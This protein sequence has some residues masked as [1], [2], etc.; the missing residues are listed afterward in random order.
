[1]EASQKAAVEIERMWWGE[2]GGDPDLAFDEL[3]N[4]VKDTAQSLYAQIQQAM[5]E[6]GK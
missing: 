4:R 1:M 5:S 2:H 6:A 3:L